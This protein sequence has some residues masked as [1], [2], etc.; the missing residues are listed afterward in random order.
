MDWRSRITK[1]STS[2]K[3]ADGLAFIGGVV[4]LIQSWIYAHTQASVLDEG[5]YLVKGYH[6]AIGKYFPFQD[7]D[8]NSLLVLRVRDESLTLGNRYRS[9]LGN[10]DVIELS[11]FISGIGD[12][13]PQRVRIHI[14]RLHRPE[15]VDHSFRHAAVTA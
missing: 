2:S 12:F 13:D 1:I 5:A 10:H 3:F 8:V 7:F 14:R 9:V 11:R 6:F 4:Y 15:P